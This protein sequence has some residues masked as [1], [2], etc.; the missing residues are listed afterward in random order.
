M[1]GSCE[2]LDVWK[3]RGG[4]AAA[5][6]PIQ[7]SLRLLWADKLDAARLQNQ[8]TVVCLH[9]A[10]ISKRLDSHCSQHAPRGHPLALDVQRSELYCCACRD[11]VYDPDFDRC[12][13]GAAAS[14]LSGDR[15]AHRAGTGPQQ[16]AAANALKRKR[17]DESAGDLRIIGP[18]IIQRA[19]DLPFGLRGLSNLGNTC[20]MN[21]VL[22]ALLHAPPLRNFYL[23]GSHAPAL[24]P[25]RQ[26]KPCLS[27]ELDG[28]FTA[29]YSGASAPFSPAAFLY[30]WWCHAE[31][32]LAG[33]Q[34]QDAHEFYLFA[35]SG[36]SHSR[37]PGSDGADAQPS[38]SGAAAAAA[39]THQQPGAGGEA[40]PVK[41]E[42]G[43]AGWRV[44]VLAH[45]GFLDLT[46]DLDSSGLPSLLTPGLPNGSAK[47]GADDRPSSHERAS[48]SRSGEAEG[49]SALQRIFGGVLQSDVTCC[50]CGHTST[51]HD[52]FL[53]ISL[54]IKPPPLPPPPLLRPPAPPHKHANGQ[55]RL[56]GAAAMAVA[57]A[58]KRAASA[59]GTADPS[60]GTSGE[61]AALPF[62]A[63]LAAAASEA[64]AHTPSPPDDRASPDTTAAS[65][66]GEAAS[67]ALPSAGNAAA[68]GD[69]SSESLDIIGSFNREPSPTINTSPL[70]D[71]QNLAITRRGST[72]GDGGCHSSARDASAPVAST[73]RGGISSEG[74]SSGIIGDSQGGVRD[75]IPV[76]SPAGR[77][78]DANSERPMW[79]PSSAPLPSN[80]HQ[81]LMTPPKAPARPRAG[82][83][84][85]K[86]P[87]PTRCMKCAT[88]LKPQLKKAC[89]RNKALRSSGSLTILDEPSPP[90]AD[91]AGPPD[92]VEAS[93]AP[94]QRPTSGEEEEAHAAVSRSGSFS[95]PTRGSLPMPITPRGPAPAADA[96]HRS[97]SGENAAGPTAADHSP[98]VTER[99]SAPAAL[100]AA[101]ADAAREAGPVGQGYGTVTGATGPAPVMT[102]YG[103]ASLVGCL[104]R[105]V[106]PESLGPGER[107]TC[108]RCRL[109]QRAVKQMSI[110]RLPLVLCL[111]VKRFEH[112]GVGKKLNTP[113]IFAPHL[114]VR[115]Y[116]S[117]TVLRKRFTAK[118][119]PGAGGPKNGKATSPTDG[120][121]VMYELYAVVCHRGN[122]QG[123]HYVAYIK[124]KS[125][126]YL[127]D[128]GF[129][130]EVDEATACSPSAYMLYYRHPAIRA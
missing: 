71:G 3:E 115:P 124:C 60:A 82:S 2:H 7:R 98:E 108:E 4:G 16:G 112:M 70:L 45:S 1:G 26:S 99:S 51:A 109:Q 15:T 29:A 72:E 43:S 56:S 24:C 19:H 123:G 113:L 42:S 128:D 46:S 75:E 48:S 52:P 76:N 88:C 68:G 120:D 8:P 114:D 106:R 38:S 10:A 9:C 50:A 119:T 20:F 117:S 21:S 44:P 126:W 67:C 23:G 65:M 59:A 107:W 11:Y 49:D 91:L 118:H 55:R 34:Q 47:F 130:L 81:P 57:A 100:G 121:S 79:R 5:Y 110:R 96:L 30:A 95:F 125:S 74:A 93:P 62:G 33:Y 63:T 25:H 101:T 86:K 27:C 87:R 129:V 127:C 13:S 14:A 36:L 12:V 94:L 22:Q 54:D 78:I 116:L 105:F 17:S 37:L 85:S 40:L 58:Q 28:L 97:T 66:V 32:H 35:L 83:A 92:I 39:A 103:A 31:H 102:Q 89:L 84:A 6:R 69:E 64:A 41:Q 90:D 18:R 104:H 73:T 122:L 111:H 61:T 53:D 80:T 77:G